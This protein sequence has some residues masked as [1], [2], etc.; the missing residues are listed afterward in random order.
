MD[1]IGYGSRVWG[2]LYVH[3]FRVPVGERGELNVWILYVRDVRLRVVAQR[4]SHAGRSMYGSH[5][6][7]MFERQ[8]P[9]THG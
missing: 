6:L 4:G 3:D 5:T 7:V 9:P 8:G 2:R 1:S